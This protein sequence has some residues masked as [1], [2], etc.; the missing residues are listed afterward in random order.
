MTEPAAPGAAE[1][2]MYLAVL[3]Q[4][5][6]TSFREAV[7]EDAAAALALM[8]LGLL[9][10]QT[11][12]GTLRAVDPRAVA[13][14]TGN[15]LRAEGLARLG[16][17]DRVADQLADLAEAYDTA[18]RRTARASTV[19]HVDE[20]EQIRHRILQLEADYREEAL[21]AQPGNRPAAHLADDGRWRAALDRGVTIQVLYQPDTY[22]ERSTRD[23]AARASR[24]G[25]RF[26]VLDE[27]FT[28]MLVFD[29]RVAVIPASPDNSSAAFVEDPAAVD[30][31]VSAFLRDWER[32]ERV[33]WQDLGQQDGLTVHQQIG[34]LLAEGLTQRAVAGRLGLSERTVAGHIA[35]LRDVYDAQTLFQLGWQMRGAE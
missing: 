18:P 24:W 15:R 19:R 1:R 31:L 30:T 22:R 7:T 29:R 20:M 14:R 12:D 2:A 34:R 3:A 26:R 5:G 23:Y 33:R 17:A 32:A 4:G 21:A 16:R 25:M 6:R 27:A 13:G 10:H 28:R 11:V 35:G 8:R 9:V